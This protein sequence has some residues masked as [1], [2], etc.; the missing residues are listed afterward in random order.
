MQA[1]RLAS[2]RNR[3][4]EGPIKLPACGDCSHDSSRGL[5]ACLIVKHCRNPLAPIEALG[6]LRGRLPTGWIGREL[7]THTLRRGRHHPS[8]D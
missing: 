8:K 4:R 2:G 6:F 1:I 3:R 7:I 5:S